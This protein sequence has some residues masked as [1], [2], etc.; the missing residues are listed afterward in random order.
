MKDSPRYMMATTAIHKLG[1]ISREEPD[2]CAVYGED[3]E[4]YIGRWATGFGFFNVKFPKTTTRELTE[5][6][7]ARY[8]GSVVSVGGQAYRILID[9]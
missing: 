7:R 6:E 3:D 2:L 9:S 5:E 1:D 8:R 4:N